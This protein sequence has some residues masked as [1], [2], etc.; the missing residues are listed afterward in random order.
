MSFRRNCST[1]SGSEYSRASFFFNSILDGSV[2]GW[3]AGAPVGAVVISGSTASNGASQITLA[4]ANTG[5]NNATTRNLYTV[6]DHVYWTHGHHQIEAGVWLQRLQS[7]DYLAQNQYG[8]ASFSTIATFEQG[9]VAKYTIVPAPTELGW[10]S[11]FS[12]GIHRRAWKVTPRLELRAGLRLESRG[13]E[14]VARAGF[15]LRL[16][17][18]CHQYNSDRGTVGALG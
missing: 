14:R 8:Q 9:Q 5:S 7:N 3:V 11:L 18:W 10:R 13:M 16:Y 17:G 1:R 15:E 2:P 12:G 6:D 4:G